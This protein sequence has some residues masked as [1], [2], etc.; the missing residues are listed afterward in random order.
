MMLTI[1][2][3]YLSSVYPLLWNVSS[4]ILPIGLLKVFNF[5]EV[6]FFFF[7]LLWIMP[8]M[9]LPYAR[10]QKFYPK[11]KKSFLVLHFIF[12]SVTHYELIFA[13]DVRL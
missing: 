13:K 8:L 3:A 4:C 10:S 12:N 7:F 5:D 1:F 9:S 6:L 11:L 2:Y